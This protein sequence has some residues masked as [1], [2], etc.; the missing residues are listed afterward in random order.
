MLFDVSVDT[1]HMINNVAKTLLK[2]VDNG[3]QILCSGL[4]YAK[5]ELPEVK[6]IVND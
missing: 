5:D 1:I 6:E 2:H 3:V 4:N